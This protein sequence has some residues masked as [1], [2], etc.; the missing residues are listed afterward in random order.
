MNASEAM[1]ELAEFL[2]LAQ[3]NIAASNAFNECL[4][5]GSGVI[6]SHINHGAAGL[7]SD[8]IVTFQINERLKR[9]LAA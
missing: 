5:D 9:F 6:L 4:K 7:A 1:Q 3:D 2:S 8:P